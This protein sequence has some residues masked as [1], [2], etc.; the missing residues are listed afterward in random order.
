MAPPPRRSRRLALKHITIGDL[1]PH[2]LHHILLGPSDNLLRFVAACA[3]VCA[4]WRRVVAGSA[5]YGLALPLGRDE[6]RHYRIGEENL[7]ERG[8]V[9]KRIAE[10]LAREGDTLSVSF[11]HIGDSGAAVLGAVLQAMPRIRY[12]E[13]RFFVNSL[14]A[15]GASSLVP[16]LRRCW[17]VGGL[18][19]LDFGRNALGDAGVAALAKALPPSLESLDISG[20]GCGDDGLVALAAALP[21]LARLENLDCG[22]NPAATA[23][24]WVALAG[25]LPPLPA[26]KELSAMGSTGMGSEGAAALVAALPQCPR[27]R[28]VYLNDCDLDAQA[29]AALRAAAARVPRSAERPGGLSLGLGYQ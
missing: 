23:C 19:S 5:A 9:L 10:R 3:R 21:A 4:E 13:F 12:T 15:A 18:V 29:K 26:L 8:R 27:L 7:G 17:G 14:T 6:G 20:T 28:W 22:T 24:G 1:P 2:V 11:A 25:A 16:A